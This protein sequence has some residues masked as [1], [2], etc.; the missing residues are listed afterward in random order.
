M[1]LPVSAPLPEPGIGLAHHSTLL[2]D[3]GTLVADGPPDA[4]LT[5]DR[6]RAVYG[7]TSRIDFATTPP[8]VAPLDRWTGTPDHG[9]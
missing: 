3:R 9:E 5:Q 1:V 8:L 4:V 6:L 2:L 7:I